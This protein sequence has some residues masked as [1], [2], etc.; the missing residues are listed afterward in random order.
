MENSE[1]PDAN[2]G[3]MMPPLSLCVDTDFAQASVGIPKSKPSRA[4]TKINEL[5]YEN[6]YDLDGELGPFLNAVEGERECYEVDED[7]E[8]PDVICAGSDSGAV[9][10]SI[11]TKR[12]KE[13]FSDDGSRDYG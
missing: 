11:T 12:A 8:F 3:D 10:S 6:Q 7:G 9:A 13:H 2:G 1:I 4:I 5:T